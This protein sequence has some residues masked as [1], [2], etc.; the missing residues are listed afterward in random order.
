MN[1]PSVFGN[2]MGGYVAI[3][4]ALKYP[5]RLKNIIP[6][7]TKF[8]WNLG[9][10]KGESANLNPKKVKVKNPKYATYLEKMHSPNH[11]RMSC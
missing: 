7:G 8:L 11:G 5:D 2:S 3:N 10:A 4:Q 6:L 1:Q 9:V